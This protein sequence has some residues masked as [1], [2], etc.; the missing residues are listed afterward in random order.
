MGGRSRV[1]LGWWGVEDRTFEVEGGWDL[2]YLSYILVK[3]VKI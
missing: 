3:S 1:T 2:E